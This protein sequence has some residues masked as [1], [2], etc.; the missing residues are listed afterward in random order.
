MQQQKTWDPSTATTKSAKLFGVKLKDKQEEAILSF[1]QGHDTFVFLPT[2]YGKS[3]MV[4]WKL[5]LTSW[6]VGKYLN[7]YRNV[8]QFSPS[9]LV[10]HSLE[11][12]YIT[13]N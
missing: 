13:A 9:L 6:K 12:L 8:L 1:V 7:A 4:F 2:G 3:F 10:L 5:Y 11:L